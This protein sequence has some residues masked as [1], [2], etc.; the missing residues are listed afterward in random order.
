MAFPVIAFL[1]SRALVLE[2]LQ[3]A[4]VAADEDHQGFI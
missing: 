1:Q 2:A 3:L 4:K